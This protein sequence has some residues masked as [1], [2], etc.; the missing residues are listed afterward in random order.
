MTNAELSNSI[1]TAFIL[2]IIA[3]GLLT[4]FAIIWAFLGFNSYSFFSSGI[5]N[6]AF[7]CCLLASPIILASIALSMASRCKGSKG[8]QKVLVILT[9]IL[10]ISAIADTAS[11]AML[12][13][14]L[15]WLIAAL[16]G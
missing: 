12:F 13:F 10:S 5:L 7:I 1:K 2:S 4:V 11:I 8:K 15:A 14:L 3:N 9:R 16:L 6:I